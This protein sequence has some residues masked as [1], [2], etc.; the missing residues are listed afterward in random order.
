MPL[1]SWP[2]KMGVS[3]NSQ[4]KTDFQNL[5]GAAP[6][7]LCRW[8]MYQVGVRKRRILGFGHDP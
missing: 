1:A 8:P 7:I 2:T 5:P 3:R 4:N 6:P